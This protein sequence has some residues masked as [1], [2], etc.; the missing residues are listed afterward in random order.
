M[1]ALFEDGERFEHECAALVSDHHEMLTLGQGE[2]ISAAVSN[3]AVYLLFNARR[4]LE[5]KR[6]AFDEIQLIYRTSDRTILIEMYEGYEYVLAPQS[7]TLTKTTTGLAKALA[8]WAPNRIVDQ[9]HLDLLPDGR[10]M[11]LF[12]LSPRHDAEGFDWSLVPDPSLTAAEAQPYQ[13][14]VKR[15]TEI[16]VKRATQSSND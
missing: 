9:F 15:R 11:T 1:D 7:A 8:A 14:A 13:T 6:L 16:I 2:L 5:A 12:Q 4:P 3:Q 10:G